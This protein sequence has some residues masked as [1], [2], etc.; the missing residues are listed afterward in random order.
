MEN[1]LGVNA[2]DTTPENE[3]VIG[4]LGAQQGYGAGVP[5]PGA[6]EAYDR[7]LAK[8]KEVYFYQT[9]LIEQLR[10]HGSV[11]QAI[12]VADQALAAMRKVSA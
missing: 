1:D 8:E 3:T 7:R 12:E 2:G 9:V 5:Y 11:T 4:N 10:Q 6:T